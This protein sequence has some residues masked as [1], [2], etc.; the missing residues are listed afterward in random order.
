MAVLGRFKPAVLEA[1]DYLGVL[2]KSFCA[3]VSV[4]LP[5]PPFGFGFRPVYN[6]EVAA[7]RFGVELTFV[8]DAT[9]DGLDSPNVFFA[10]G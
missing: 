6:L 7:G 2:S 10:A 3:S 5:R 9:V 8:D 1:A 4:V